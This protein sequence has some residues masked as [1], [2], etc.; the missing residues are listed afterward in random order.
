MTIIIRVNGASAAELSR[1]VA[2]AEASFKAA[3]VQPWRGANGVSARER[4]Q[5]AGSAVEAAP[6]EDQMEAAA[7]MDQAQRAAGSACCEGWTELPEK[8]YL[9]V[10]PSPIGGPTSRRN[11]P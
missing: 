11:A 9:E 5:L 7:A 2:A 8:I 10:V 4:W 1:G 3:G 6:T